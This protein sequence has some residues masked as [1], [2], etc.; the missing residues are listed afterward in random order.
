MTSV[1]LG[2]V[3]VNCLLLLKENNKTKMYR[4]DHQH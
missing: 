1:L 2:V 4:D 3:L